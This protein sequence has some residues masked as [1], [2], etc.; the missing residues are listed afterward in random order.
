MDCNWSGIRFIT[1]LF[2]ESGIIID[3]SRLNILCYNAGGHVTEQEAR[4]LGRFIK[5]QLISSRRCEDVSREWLQD[6]MVF[7][8][9]CKGFAVW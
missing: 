8:E 7:C 9:S 5:E 6:V 2:L 1:S 4:A 3:E